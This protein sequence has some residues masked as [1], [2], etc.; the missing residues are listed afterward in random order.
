MV[1]NHRIIPG[2]TPESVIAR[3]KDT[4]GD[5][6]V[7]IRVI[8]GMNPSRIS[9]TDGMAWE[10]LSSCVSDTWRGSVVSPY[11]M[12]AC[13]D[14]RHFGEIC[15]KVYRF[16]PLTLSKEERGYIHGNNERIPIST[17]AKAVEF[18]IRFIKTS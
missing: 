3:I 9:S 1:S 11:L 12:L 8:D 7:N 2:E 17:V 15:D 14:S 18:Y 16:S 5:G 4:V 10:L 13:S 6:E